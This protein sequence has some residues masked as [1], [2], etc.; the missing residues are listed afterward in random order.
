MRYA[1]SAA[2]GTRLTEISIVAFLWALFCPLVGM[3]QQGTGRIL[4]FDSRIAVTKDRTFV[5]K[6][7]V[8]ID[9]QGA[10]DQ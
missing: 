7:R 1:T 10:F 9:N 4:T 3:A 8:E 5:V 6:E 2:P